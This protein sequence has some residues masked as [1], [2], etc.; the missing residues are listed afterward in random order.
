MTTKEQKLLEEARNVSKN[1]YTPYSNFNVGAAILLKDGSII[2]GANVENCAYG[3]SNCAERSALFYT[4][5]QGFRKDDIEMMAVI[6]DT[7]TPASPCG[8]CR[9]VMSELLT[10]ECPLILGTLSNDQVMIS[11]I[12]TLL[13]YSFSL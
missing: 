3:P 2:T 4:F 10:P 7:D 12:K 8:V 6:T 13:P 1:A 11:D 9:Q 5:S